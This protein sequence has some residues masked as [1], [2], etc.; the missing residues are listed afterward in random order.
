MIYEGFW[1][2][3]VGWMV[4]W[5]GGIFFEISKLTR[6]KQYRIKNFK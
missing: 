2:V 1:K 5:G 4:G 3:G 6:G